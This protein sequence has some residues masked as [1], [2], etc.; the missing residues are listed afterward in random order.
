V[1]ATHRGAI[2]AFLTE[3][4]PPPN[5]PVFCHNDLGTEH[6]LVDPDTREVTGV[7]DWTDAAMADPAYDL[8]LLYRDLGPQVAPS[9]AAVFYARCAVLEDLKY[10]VDEGREMYKNNALAALAWLF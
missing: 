2:E 9:E 10:G 1:P 8:G 6:V 3:T 7:I 4:P 5:P